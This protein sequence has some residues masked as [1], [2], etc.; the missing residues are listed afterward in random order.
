MLTKRHVYMQ[1]R[2]AMSVFLGYRFV[3]LAMA[4]VLGAWPVARAF[5]GPL[6]VHIV[7]PQATD[8]VIDQALDNHYAWIDPTAPTNGQLF[9][10][11]P[12]TADVPANALLVQQMA[13]RLGYH[14]I[15]LMYVD[16][17]QI[18]G[19]CV[20]QPDPSTCSYDARFEILTGQDVS[21]LV[22]VNVPNSI[23][24]RLTK[25]LQYLAI[26]YP[27]EGW[28]T[29]LAGGHPQW[30][31]IAVGGWSQGGAQAAF[32]A[33]FR[34]VARVVMFSAPVESYGGA[35]PTW[36]STGHVTPTGRYFGLAHDR[37]GFYPGIVG[38]WTALGMDAL[39]AQ[40]QVEN[41]TPP[42]SFTH[43]LFTDLHPQR[44]GYAA[45]HPSTV[46]DIYTPLFPDKTPRLGDA[47]KYML[48]AEVPE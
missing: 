6:T 10:Y 25:L 16:G 14:V 42:Y 41:T 22:D 40:V 46:L 4:L 12:G 30:S 38:G 39:G 26:N 21:A 9:V 33:K 8:P 3:L 27:Q 24:N 43:E 35:P 45:A 19:L 1:G 44:N 11:M 5:A 37:D 47:W 31:K 36:E 7:N 20:G 34:Y 32:I 29:F 15:G 28:S 17:T 2:P 18:Q 13:A 23:D 48:T